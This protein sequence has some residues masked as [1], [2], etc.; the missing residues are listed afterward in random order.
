MDGGEA[1]PEPV[2]N[3]QRIQGETSLLER[4]ADG[5]VRVAVTFAGQ[6]VNWWPD[7]LRLCE[8]RPDLQP[9]I[10]A[11]EAKM[12]RVADSPESVDRGHFALGAEL[13]RWREDPD[14]VPP[15]SYLAAGVLSA[16]MIFAT[17]MLQWAQVLADGLGD[18][19]ADHPISAVSGESQGLLAAALVSA[20]RAPTP[21][22]V[23]AV[24]EA[25]A[26]GGVASGSVTSGIVPSGIGT[27]S[28]RSSRGSAVTGPTPLAAVTGLRSEEIDR[29]IDGTEVHRAGRETP[30]RYLLAGEPGALARL[31]G[32]LE[33]GAL[34]SNPAL[35]WEWIE[36]DAP[37]HSPLAALASSGADLGTVLKVISSMS[38]QPGQPYDGW[39]IPLVGA[40]S[41]RGGALDLSARHRAAAARSLLKESSSPIEWPTTVRALAADGPDGYAADW[42]LDIGP[43]DGLA[44][45]SQRCLEGSGCRVAPLSTSAGQRLLFT[46]GEAPD[47]PDVRWSESGCRVEQ[48]ANG[49]IRIGGRHRD[50]TGRSPVILAGMTPT[51]VDPRIVAAAANAGFQ[52]E[53]AGGGQVTQAVLDEH[54]GQLSNLL[55]PGQEVVFNALLL[56][57]YLWGLHLGREKLVLKAAR[58]GAPICG[59]TVSAGVP[60]PEDG[61][62]LL[63]ELHT[64][65]M[66][67]N[68]L[69]PGT[70]EQVRAALRIADLRPD[71]PLWLHLEGG[72]AGGTPLPDHPRRPVA[73]H[74][75]PDSSASP[76]G[77]GRRRWHRHGGACRCVAL[78]HLEPRLR[79]AGYAG[80]RGAHRHDGDG[81]HRSHG[82]PGRQGGAD[83]RYGG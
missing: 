80:R 42:I 11:I 82:Q 27:S 10:E 16:P 18:A 32:R 58:N 25:L 1:R 52:A 3:A 53:L 74:L 75:R 48:G 13:A 4:I 56:E 19:T 73:L 70:P 54:L 6:G 62:E 81:R 72:E 12:G 40:A 22:Q 61:A 24:L 59:V 15:G 35:A 33:S 76:R 51:T 71:R 34:G 43:G 49:T 28:F 68:A 45:A 9:W 39:S 55:D 38:P 41:N 26:N 20:V 78:R 30:T 79:R 60:D 66:W 57:P 69:K 37:Y 83:R 8:E 21:E 77:V 47:G 65:G 64:A 31:E 5:R 36:V 29:F 14:S 63:D 23:A 44:R 50:L 7:Y 2:D 67:L 17:Q 46:A